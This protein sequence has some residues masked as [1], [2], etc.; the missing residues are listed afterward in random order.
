[1]VDAPP[2]I[3]VADADPHVRALVGRFV[4]EAGYKVTY[5]VDGYEALDDARKSPP[6]AILAD[7]LLPRLDGLALCRLLK[8]DPTTSHII[9]VIVFSVLS[10]EEKARKAGA[11]AFVRKPL[12]KN[13]VLNTLKEAISSRGTNL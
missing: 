7:M 9:T 3:M 1:M 11:D 12:E 5:A 13:R 6:V 8:N 2:V 10:A 4:G